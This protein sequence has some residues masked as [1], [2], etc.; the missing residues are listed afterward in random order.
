LQATVVAAG[1][2]DF[3]ITWRADVFS[4]A[5]QSSSAASFGTLGINF[6]ARKAADE[7]EWLRAMAELN[8]ELP[9]DHTEGALQ[10]R[11]SERRGTMREEIVESAGDVE[12]PQPDAVLEARAADLGAGFICAALTPLIK[13]RLR[14]ME[15]GQ[16]L[17]VRVDDPAARL[18]VPAWCRLSGNTLLAT[19]EDD[20]EHTRFY[21]RKKS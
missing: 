9:S 7:A 21:V 16:V 19:V 17:E 8:C 18:D 13:S 11:S 6:R 20:A 2:V 3:E 1:F 15:P 5:P 4:D 12:L 10:E 14:E